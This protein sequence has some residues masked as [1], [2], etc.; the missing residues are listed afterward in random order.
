M[1][2]FSYILYNNNIFKSS[3]IGVIDLFYPILLVSLLLPTLML[4]SSLTPSSSFSTNSFISSISP[5]ID[6]VDN[7][8]P[9]LLRDKNNERHCDGL[10]DDEEIIQQT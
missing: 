1:I 3:F 10:I 8:L 7:I 5:I 9:S 2:I 4:M 6:E